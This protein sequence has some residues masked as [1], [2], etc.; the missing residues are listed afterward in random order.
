MHRKLVVGNWK[1]NG[2]AASIA[3]LLSGVRQ[4][5]P[6]L[7]RTDVAVCPSF[8]YLSL[9]QQ[10]LHGGSVAIG[11]QNVSAQSAGAF[12]GEVAASMLHDCG[13]RYVIVGHSER[14]SLYGEDDAVV[15]AKAVAALTHGVTPIVC[16]GETLA[17]RDAGAALSTIGTQLDAVLAA[18]GQ[19]RVLQV[20]LAYEPLWAI[21]TGRTATPAQAQEVHGFIRQRLQALTTKAAAVPII[22]GGSVKADN[23][24]SLFAEPD[25]DGA[26]VGGA[27]LN[28][29][30]FVAICKAAE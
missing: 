20:V 23:A 11:A 1:M 8:V 2:N 29:E 4:Q 30:E 10:Q 15:A 21:G 17:E 26:L 28:P 24:A 3:Q 12:T 22:Y 14:R 7:T 27:S 13:C 16:V 9:A 18:L 19:E 5:L 25:I 6:A